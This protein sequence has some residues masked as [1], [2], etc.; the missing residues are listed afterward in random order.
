MRWTLREAQMSSILMICEFH[1]ILNSLTDLD[2]N[3]GGL[4]EGTDPWKRNWMACQML[5]WRCRTRHG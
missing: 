3:G 5:S 4:V 2:I 1:R